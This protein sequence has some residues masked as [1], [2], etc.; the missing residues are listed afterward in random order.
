MFTLPVAPIS[1][2]VVIHVGIMLSLCTI[3]IYI[4]LNEH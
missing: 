1:T 2:L 4:S 3:M